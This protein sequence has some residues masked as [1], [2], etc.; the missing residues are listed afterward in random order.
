MNV[1]YKENACHVIAC[2]FSGCQGDSKQKLV[3]N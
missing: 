2:H 3:Y 1:Q